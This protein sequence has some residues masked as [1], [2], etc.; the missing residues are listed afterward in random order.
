[1]LH[2]TAHKLSI[3]VVAEWVLKTN[4]C[5]ISTRFKPQFGCVKCLH[6]SF[7]SLSH[8]SHVWII[9]AINGLE[10]CWDKRNHE[11]KQD[12]KGMSFVLESC[13]VHCLVCSVNLIYY[14]FLTYIL[15]FCFQTVQLKHIFSYIFFLFPTFW[16]VRSSPETECFFRQYYIE[17]CTA[18]HYK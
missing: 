1:M 14:F 18:L 16:Q 9:S 3:N 11:V 4:V 7:Q 8:C 10:E 12:K 15:F 5:L 6:G 17:A 13:L 2:T